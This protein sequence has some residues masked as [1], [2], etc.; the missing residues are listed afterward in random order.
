MT[1]EV[2]KKDVVSFLTRAPLDALSW[3]EDGVA[4]GS[5]QIEE[6]A[7]GEAWIVSVIGEIPE[8][9]NEAL[10]SHNFRIIN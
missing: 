1:V 5:I 8:S 3:Y 9:V 2:D 6:S 4:D 10:L 7:S